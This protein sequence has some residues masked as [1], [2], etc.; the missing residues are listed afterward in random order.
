[1]KLGLQIG[2][3]LINQLVKSADV[4]AV[5]GDIMTDEL[6]PADAY[7]ADLQDLYTEVTNKKS[8][9]AKESTPRVVATPS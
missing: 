3:G 1:M 4:S 7:R 5:P 6:S 8:T 2:V 9:T